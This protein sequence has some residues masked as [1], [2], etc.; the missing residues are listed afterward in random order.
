MLFLGGIFNLN[1]GL[2][3]ILCNIKGG[4]KLI[5]C[6]TILREFGTV[7]SPLYK[8][9]W[10]TKNNKKEQYQKVLWKSHQKSTFINIPKT[11]PKPTPKYQHLHKTCTKPAHKYQKYSKP[12]LNQPSSAKYSPMLHYIKAKCNIKKGVLQHY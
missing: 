2:Y 1:V 9:K 8:R 5:Q 10:G 12:T 7:N 11:Y 6:P 4:L 3:W